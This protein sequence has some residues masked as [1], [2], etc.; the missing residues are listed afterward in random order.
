M[1]G[2][3][4]G[5]GDVANEFLFPVILPHLVVRKSLIGFAHLWQSVCDKTVPGEGQFC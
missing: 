3:R 2:K 4:P 1:G 5:P